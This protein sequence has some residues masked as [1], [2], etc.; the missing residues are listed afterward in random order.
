MLDGKG[1]FE[2]HARWL[3][4]FDPAIPLYSQESR[5]PLALQLRGPGSECTQT[6]IRFLPAFSLSELRTCFSMNIQ[7]LGSYLSHARTS[8]GRLVSDSKIVIIK[9]SKP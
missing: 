3:E 1:V 8:A 5:S 4:A 9:T 2:W 6:C 7:G